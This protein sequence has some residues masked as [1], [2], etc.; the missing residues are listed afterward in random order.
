VSG[1]AWPPL[2]GWKRG[3]RTD[4]G[5]LFADSTANFYVCMRMS[6][7]PTKCW[8]RT[9]QMSRPGIR[10]AAC[11]PRTILRVMSNA[12]RAP[13]WRGTI[14]EYADNTSMSGPL[15]C[16]Q[17]KVESQLM[18]LLGNIPKFNIKPLK[19]PTAT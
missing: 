14:E 12:S 19:R 3:R 2:T 13:K 9:G 15:V 1:I 4:T 16:F 8:L 18:Q 10:L 7:Q 5:F 6:K 17:A 11:C